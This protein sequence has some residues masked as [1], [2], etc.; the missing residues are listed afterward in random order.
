MSHLNIKLCD[1]CIFPSIYSW[2]YYDILCLITSWWTIYTVL[3]KKVLSSSHTRQHEKDLEGKEV[4]RSFS[5][6]RVHCD[7]LLNNMWEAFNNKIEE[8]SFIPTATK[9]LDKIKS[10]AEQYITTF[11]GCRTLEKSVY[12]GCRSTKL[13]VKEKKI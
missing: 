7:A 12:C 11:Y 1:L 9:I 3:W 4:Q 6:M 10:K 8:G 5:G 13:H 2:I